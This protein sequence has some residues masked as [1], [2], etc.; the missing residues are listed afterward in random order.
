MQ[1]I[2]D[3]FKKKTLTYSFEFFPPKTD[4]GFQNLLETICGLAE[5]QPDFVSCTYG[6]GGGNREKTFDIV[7][8]V[9]DEHGIVGLAHLTC[10]LNT[11]DELKVIL[12]DIKGRGICNVLA[13]R[14]DPPLDNPGW[15]PGPDN[16]KYSYELCHF[17]R[18]NFEGH[19]AI[20]VAGFP[21]GH[22][23]CRDKEKDAGYLKMKLDNGA[24][25][26]ITQLFLDNKN[27]FEYVQRLRRLGVTA[28]IIPGIL[29]IADYEKVV[30]FCANDGITIPE[31]VKKIFEPI[32]ADKE[33]TLA[34]GIKFTVRQCRELL[35]AGAPGL[36]FY[37]LNKVH[38]LDEILGQV[39]R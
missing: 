33:K 3:I 25:F 17:I 7:Q 11:K 1:K 24:D 8:H 9:Q 23:L 35:D 29:P 30:R 2:P 34:E 18:Q 14:G 10:V 13:L 27:Y 28:R 15:A 36:H 32:Q 31:E 19:F 6:A 39:R 16:F 22:I 20:G 26:V 21:E 37:T 4:K 38:P 5:F 12:N